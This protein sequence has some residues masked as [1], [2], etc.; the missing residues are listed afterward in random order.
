MLKGDKHGRINYSEFLASG[1]SSEEEDGG[2]GN[3]S[4]DDTSRLRPEKRKAFAA[5]LDS[6]HNAEG[7]IPP[8]FTTE[9]L[10]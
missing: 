4:D 2:G 5:L 10:F 6:L 1:S 7:V 3:S 8:Q 9:T